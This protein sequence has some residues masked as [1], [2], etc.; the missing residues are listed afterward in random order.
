MYRLLIAKGNIGLLGNRPQNTY[1]VH[2]DVNEDTSF[3]WHG[4]TAGFGSFFSTRPS[5]NTV[6][7]E[8]KVAPKEKKEKITKYSN[9]DVNPYDK[10]D[11]IKNKPVRGDNYPSLENKIAPRTGKVTFV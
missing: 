1:E 8:N 5:S 7:I 6:K 9:D 2:E 10:V 4:I 11:K 3:S